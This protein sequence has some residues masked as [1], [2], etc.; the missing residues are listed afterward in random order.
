MKSFL[1]ELGSTLRGITREFPQSEVQLISFFPHH[2][3]RGE[4][5]GDEF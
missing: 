1:N 2:E 4:V 5:F 3:D